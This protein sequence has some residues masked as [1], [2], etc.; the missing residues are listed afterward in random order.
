MESSVYTRD[1]IR[2]ISYPNAA[3]HSFYL[4]LYVRAGSMH[5]S[6]SG[7]THFF[8]H[9]AIRNI[10]YNMQ[11]ELYA[12][13]DR[14]GIEFNASTSSEMIQFYIAGAKQHTRLGAEL[15]CRVLD[16]IT[17]PVSE[18]NRERDRIRAEIREVDEPST[19]QGFT[20]EKLFA[21][22]TLER[23]I[24]GTLGSV[25]R[26][27]RRALEE[28]RASILTAD[29]I[30]LYA[31]G[32]VTDDD[33]AYLSACLDRYSIPKGVKREN[34]APVP[35]NF[36]HRGASVYIKNAPFTKVRFNFDIDMTRIGLRELDIFYEQLLGGYSSEFFL[37]LSEKRGLIYDLSG[38]V[39]RYKNIAV[40]SFSFEVKEQRLYEAVE[41]AVSI[42]RSYKERAVDP[43]K[44]MKAS[45]VD[46]AFMLFDD[47]RELNFTFAYDNH[48]M[49]C[50]YPDL[51]ARRAAYE[52]VSPDDILALARCILL[53]EN[54]TLTVKGRAKR[55]DS[56]R[57][58]EIL[59]R[60]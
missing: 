29:N 39:D 5:E 59:L 27:S 33:I 16:E 38:N 51:A 14:C 35:A 44:M 8:E 36:A 42:L 6:L 24:T 54:L 19:L 17:L 20:Q 34:L 26:I 52:S 1:G 43:D 55:L 53:P 31:T 58:R 30:F 12:M 7:I 28:Y 2:I 50:D 48:F 11:G 23:C 22:T 18:I 21:G 56:D 60:L 46:N 47:I 9:V 41:L 49:D 37:E 10:N 45:F 57:L 15:L 40:L 4:S 32:D 25:A 3:S 13:L